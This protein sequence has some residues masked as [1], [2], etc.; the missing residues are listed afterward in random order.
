[1]MPDIIYSIKHYFLS[2]LL[3]EVRDIFRELQFML[4]KDSSGMVKA[5]ILSIGM[6]ASIVRKGVLKTV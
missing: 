4:A 2:W 5:S 3:F 6:G 1:M